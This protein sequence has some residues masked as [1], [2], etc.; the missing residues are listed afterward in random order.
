[1]SPIDPNQ[2]P[3]LGPLLDRALELSA[4]EREEWLAQLRATSPE[5]AAALTELLSADALAER[6]GFLA[7]PRTMSLAGLELGAYTLIRPLGHGGMGSVWLARRTDGRFE[8][9]SAVKLMNLALMTE[10]G[11]ARFRREGTALARLTHPAIA[12]LLDA[13]VAPS[14][15]PYLVIEYVDGQRIDIYAEAAGLSRDQRV[16]LVLQVL[17]AVGHAHANLIVH[18]DL[19]PSNILV[20]ADGQVKL[21]DFGIAKLLQGD[22]EG[23]RAALT[24][25]GGGALTPDYASPEQVRGEIVTTATDVYALGVL[26]YLLMSGRHP[27]RGPSSTPAET[28]RAVLEVDPQPLGLGDLDT[29]IAKALR[30]PPAERYQTVAAFGDDLRRYL[31]HEPVSARPDSLT[32][33]VGKFIRRNR[34]GVAAAAVVA[35]VLVG[36]TVFSLTQARRAAEQRDVA[37]R[38]ARR[39]SALV[40]LQSVLAG[41][42]RRPDGQ[43]LTSAG[44]IALAEEVVVQQFRGEPWLVAEVMTDLASRFNEWGDREGERAMLARAGTIADAGGQPAHVALAACFRAM[45]FWLDDLTDSVQAEL[46]TARAALGRVPK[47]VDPVLQASCLEAEGKALQASGKGDSAVMLVEQ[48]VALVGN[49]PIGTRRRTALHTLSEVL[50]L[51]GRP[52]EAVTHQQSLLRELDEAGYHNTATFPNLVDNLERALAYLGEFSVVD[53]ILAGL[54]RKGEAAAGPGQ[55]ATLIAF[56]YGQNKLR[57][58]ETD[59]ADLWVGRAM[60]GSWQE[61]GTITNWLPSVL[62]LLRLNQGRLAEARDAVARLPGGLRGRRATAAMLKAMLA[63][64]QGDPAGASRLLE[65]E[66]TALYSESPATLSLFTLPLV[67]AGEWRLAAGDARGA[68]SLARLGRTA[69]ALDSLALSRS[70]LAGRSELL[71]ARAL[72]AQGNAPDARLAAERAIVALGNGYGATNPWTRSAR[73]LL[74][75]LPK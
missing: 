33:R 25:E 75:S 15:Q 51:V 49:D 68:D 63:R 52:R 59:S 74:D 73:A 12:R 18:R 71:L 62:A 30:K 72:R 21:L 39:A 69:A 36:A 13:G 44:R 38:A 17:D 22:G 7:E 4:E 54:V 46:A 28:V 41:D 11:Q 19:K 67:T 20:T 56:M 55:V 61:G 35:M 40:E 45:S 58:G 10:S 31:R 53:S 70:A 26:L 34:T 64:A 27:T 14:G 32:Y 57:L 6:R 42:N 9:Q 24:H 50:R 48:A 66:L 3:E 65:R 37:V 29:I 60:R 1:M 16:E 5:L 23:E 43:P 47:P 8:G 2:W